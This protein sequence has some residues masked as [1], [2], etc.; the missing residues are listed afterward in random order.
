MKTIILVEDDPA[1]REVLML[2]LSGSF[3]DCTVYEAASG[4]AFLQLVEQRTPDL[5][6]LDVRLPE[7]SGVSLYTI[8]RAHATLHAVPV[9]FVTA[10]PHRV[11]EAALVGP[12]DCLVKPFRLEDLVA[13]VQIFLGI[14][15][16][17]GVR[18]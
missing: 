3:P 2:A 12:H 17:A 9:L 10:N 7:A 8:L 18:A 6:L 14:A 13:H 11:Y 5:V 15:P 4:V 1:I 16:S